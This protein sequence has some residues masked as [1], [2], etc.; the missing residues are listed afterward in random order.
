MNSARD[1]AMPRTWPLGR[2]LVGASAAAGLLCGPHAQANNLDSDDGL[3]TETVAGRDRLKVYDNI[4]KYGAERVA[5]RDRQFAQPDGVRI[6]NF[7]VYPSIA[8]NVV[9]DDN[10][11][12]SSV[13]RT[14]DWRN[15]FRPG[16]ALQSNLP[17]HEID[18]SLAGKIVTYADNT[19]QNYEDYIAQIRGALHFDHATTMSAS[20]LSALEHEERSAIT[21]PIDAAEPV[22]VTHHRVV[23]G[24]TRDA[25]RLCG[26]LSAT[27]EDYNYGDVTA[28][29]GSTLDQSY[30]DQTIYSAQLKTGYRFSPGYDLITKFKVSRLINEGQD[31]EN[32]DAMEYEALTGLAFETDPL[33]RWRLLGGYG[34]REYDSSSLSSVSSGLL[35]GDVIWLPTQRMTVYGTIKHEIVDYIGSVGDGLIE[36]SA[37]ARIEY[38]IRHDLVGTVDLEYLDA[39]FIGSPRHDQILTAGVGLDYYYTKNWL[40]TLGYVFEDR[41]SN[42]DI[43]DTTRNRFRAGAKL[44]F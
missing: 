8:D 40:F 3:I 27:A 5:D 16:I 1:I 23:A 20:V 17:R 6:G 21:A 29:D 13:G 12:D 18:L 36:T 22:P 42:E 31:D 25:G 14:A 41:Q 7:I 44:K 30:R 19:D 2:A 37:S 43:Y 24:L 11:F 39:N 33:L 34:W 32:R 10:I 35:E 4:K 9:Y 26:T 28:T 15:E 38:E